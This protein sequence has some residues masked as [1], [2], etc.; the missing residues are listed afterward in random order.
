MGTG[1]V[2]ENVGEVRTAQDQVGG[3]IG[4]MVPAGTLLGAEWYQI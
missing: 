4:T 1:K 2:K 3:L